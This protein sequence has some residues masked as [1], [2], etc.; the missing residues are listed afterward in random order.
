[1]TAAAVEVREQPFDRLLMRFG[2]AALWLPGVAF[3]IA[4]FLVPVGFAI[5]AAALLALFFHPPKKAE[6]VGSP[7]LPGEPLASEPS[8]AAVG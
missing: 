1:M 8:P 3:M 2:P 4:F 7:E 6:P 5:F